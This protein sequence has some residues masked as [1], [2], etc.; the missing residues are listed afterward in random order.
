M[1]LIALHAIAANLLVMVAA[2][3]F[4]SWIPRLLPE[5]FSRFC[6]RGVRCDRRIRAAWLDRFSGWPH[7]PDTLDA[8]RDSRDRR[9]AGDLQQS[10]TVAIKSTDR[11]STRGDCVRHAR[12]NRCCRTG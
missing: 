2:W 8:G 1:W 7:F 12:A 10:T 11:E 5:T 6:A 9:R 3:S 4:G